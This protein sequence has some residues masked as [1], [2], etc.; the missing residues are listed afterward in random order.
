MVADAEQ[1]KPPIRTD[2]DEEEF[3]LAELE[4]LKKLVSPE[5]SG[6][7][8]SIEPLFSEEPSW[9]PHARWA[10]H[11]PDPQARGRFPYSPPLDDL[12]LRL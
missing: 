9:S 7:S 5:G 3:N 11:A 8:S 4:K 10:E 6:A 12:L 2:L 1:S